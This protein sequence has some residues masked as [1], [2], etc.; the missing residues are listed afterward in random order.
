MCGNAAK[1]RGERE[2]TGPTLADIPGPPSACPSAIYLT[3]PALG[4][5]QSAV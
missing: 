4:A 1:V 5:A 2:R 3:R